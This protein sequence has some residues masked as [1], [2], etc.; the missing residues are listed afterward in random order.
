MS[1]PSR[2]AESVLQ[3]IASALGSVQARA[4]WGASIAR[5]AS[6]YRKQVLLDFDCFSDWV[7]RGS[8]LEAFKTE[9]PIETAS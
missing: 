6:A 4:N 7:K 9:A 8:P 3:V 2:G 1:S 5:T